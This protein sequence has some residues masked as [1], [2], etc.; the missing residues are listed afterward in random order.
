MP[1]GNVAAVRNVPGEDGT[2]LP[3][4]V[5]TDGPIRTL[6]LAGD[7]LYLGGQFQNVNRGLAALTR[8]R[9][10][11]AAVDATTGLARDWDPDA[12]FAVN[13]LTVQ[14]NTVYAGGEF[15]RVNNG[16]PRQRLAAFDSQNGTARA[17]DPGAGAPVRSLATYGS[18]VFAGGD[19]AS[20]GGVPRSGLV[21]LDGQTGAPDSF[22][23]E[24]GAEERDGPLP[25]V[26]R[27][28]ALFASQQTG[29]LTG[30]GFVMRSPAPRS[31]NLSLFGLAPLPQDGGPGGSGGDGAGGPGIG[32]QIP[33]R[34]VLAPDLAAFGASARRF[35]VGRGATPADG[36]ATAAAAKKKK[37]PAGTT[38]T[39]RLSEP[40]RVKFEVM[41]K[42]KG[43]K[44]GKKCV[45]ATRK[46]RKRK[47]C[48]VLTLK[49]PAFTRSVPAGRSKVKWSGRLGRKAL[50]RGSY[51]LRA[52]PTDAA[53]NKG[54]A[55]TLSFTV[56][57]QS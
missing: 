19:F 3:F 9:R 41:A 36:T 14:S 29:L 16:V 28:G 38:L 6:A 10:N 21:E 27:V 44:V 55:R 33:P 8:A 48:T 47:K 54:K 50:K 45:K 30:G 17:W 46:N 13:A 56:V 7:T 35:R 39:L 53:G 4:D 37:A 34:D 52:T 22:S 20:A 49:K 15:D 1:R 11:L 40:A 5:D 57:R 26:T 32:A 12:N 24:L 43:R 25:P 2:V 42:G 18:T 51:Q 31:A 23:P